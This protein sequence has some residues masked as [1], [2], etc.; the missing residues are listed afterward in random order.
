MLGIKGVPPAPAHQLPSPLPSPLSSVPTSPKG[1]NIVGANINT[2]ITASSPYPT[3]NAN[4]ASLSCHRRPKATPHKSISNTSN[5]VKNYPDMTND[6]QPNDTTLRL[7]YYQDL[8]NNPKN[9][10]EQVLKQFRSSV[11][12]SPTT[13]KLQKNSTTLKR[14]TVSTTTST[15]SNTVTAASVVEFSHKDLPEELQDL[16]IYSI[17][18]E[19]SKWKDT[20]GAVKV[21]WRKGLPLELP[22]HLDGYSLLT[23]EEIHTCQTL[24]FLPCQ[25]LFIKRVLLSAVKEKWF[26][27]VDVQGWFRMDVNK[28]AKVYDWFVSLGWLP[29]DI[30]EWRSTHDDRKP[31][32]RIPAKKRPQTVARTPT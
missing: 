27:K 21:E 25:Y 16:D 4:D 19:G 1:G 7:D 20:Q 14:D 15:T 6:E 8:I 11:A 12:A 9:Y 22:T 28:S 32:P 31:P 29:G 13:R 5:Q 30:D 3:D 10:Y 26:R 2:N 18:L 23:T 17:D 24:R